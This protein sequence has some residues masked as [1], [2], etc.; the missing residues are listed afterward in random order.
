MVGGRAGPANRGDVQVNDALLAYLQAET[1][2]VRYL[3]AVPSSMQG[4]DYVI[5]TGR[6][7]LYLGGFSGNDQVVT[8][9]ELA[10]MVARGDLRFVYW[11]SRGGGFRQRSDISDWVTTHCAAVDGYEVM[12]RNTGAPDGAGGGTGWGGPGAAMPVSLYRCGS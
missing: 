11:N 7:V 8:G 6:P 2:G 4:A 1:Q 9:D 5:A 12:T 3:M 10:A